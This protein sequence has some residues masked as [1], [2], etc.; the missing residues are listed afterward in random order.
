MWIGY[1]NINVVMTDKEG[2]MSRF[3]DHNTESAFMDA[4]I[5]QKELFLQLEEKEGIAETQRYAKTSMEVYSN[6][7]QGDYVNQRHHLKLPQYRYKTIASIVACEEYLT[8]GTEMQNTEVAQDTQV[9][10]QQKHLQ[11]TEA[12][13]QLQ[14]QNKTEKEK[15]TKDEYFVG[16]YTND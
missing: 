10:T 2:I 13:H 9:Y 3:N 12:E 1:V 6:A 14:Y 16:V 7:L 5:R 4:M 8:Q 11:D 15:P